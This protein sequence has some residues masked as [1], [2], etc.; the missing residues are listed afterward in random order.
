MILASAR[1]D[2]KERKH[3]FETEEE[4]HTQQFGRGASTLAKTP[5]A[6]V[7]DLLPALGTLAVVVVHGAARLPDGLLHAVE[8]AVWVIRGGDGGGC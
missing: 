8:R 3:G 1:T 7:E 5:D 2:F 6:T 4:Q